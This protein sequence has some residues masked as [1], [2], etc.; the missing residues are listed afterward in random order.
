[1]ANTSNTFREDPLRSEHRA[2]EFGVRPRHTGGQRPG[3]LLPLIAVLA[4]L[5]LAYW[6]LSRRQRMEPTTP[7]ITPQTEEYRNQPEPHP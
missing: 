1:M 3:W 5:A 4:L 6:A 7:S 2:D